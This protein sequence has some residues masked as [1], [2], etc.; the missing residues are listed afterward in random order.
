MISDKKIQDITTQLLRDW[1]FDYFK[2]A[3][4]ETKHIILDRMFPKERRITSTMSGF[5]TSLGS[6][7]EK[8]STKFAEENNLKLINPKTLLAPKNSPKELESLITKTKKYREDNGGELTTLKDE[9]NNAFAHS[10]PIKTE[11]QKITKGKGADVVVEK[12]GNIYIFDIK[13]V[14]VNANNGNTFNETIILWTAYYKYLSGIDANNIHAML[15]FPYNSANENDDNAWWADFK[16]RV[17]PLTPKDVFVGNQ[18]W[19]FLTDNPNALKQI[20]TAIDQL[21]QDKDFKALY[22]KAFKVDDAKGLELFSEE[23]RLHRIQSK[24]SIKL[25]NNNSPWNLRKKFDW[26]HGECKFKERLNKLLYDED[27][28]CPVCKKSILLD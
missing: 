13:T 3:Q 28:T 27:Y 20:T 25:E 15:V 26:S 4:S 14:Q 5:Q 11:T 17:S 18:Y 1:F 21:N 6:F 24:F 23:V 16:S 10:V 9:L 12:N 2:S 22:S 8:L 7:W 19:S